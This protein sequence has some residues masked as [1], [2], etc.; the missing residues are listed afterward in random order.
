MFLA[1]CKSSEVSQENTVVLDKERTRFEYALPTANELIISDICDSIGHAQ[2]FN[3]TINTGTSET[4]ASIRNNQL[5][6]SSK[7]DTVYKDSIVFKDKLI[8]K[9]KRVDIVKYKTAMWH[10]WAHLSFLLIIIGLTYFLF[11]RS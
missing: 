10:W 11:Y 6:I 7:T 5:F 3:T 9:D 4:K 1:S 2:E 8:Y